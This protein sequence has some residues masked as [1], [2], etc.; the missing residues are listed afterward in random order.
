MGRPSH[1]RPADRSLAAC[2]RHRHRR[3]HGGRSGQ[4][5][6]GGQ[7]LPLVLV[8]VALAAA[9]GMGLV[10]VG[11][12]VAARASAKAAADAAALAGAA[13]G[14][15]AAGRI[16]RANGAVLTSFREDGAGVEVTVERR[17]VRAAARARW[18]PAGSG[19]PQG[20]G[21]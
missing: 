3:R 5:G 1:A 16:A 18:V 14:K 6:Q 15:S 10:H 4:G 11:V 13:D 12:A 19:D 20:A 17:G 2:H 8:A 21:P 7:A 9:L